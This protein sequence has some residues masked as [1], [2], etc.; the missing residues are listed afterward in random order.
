[1][2]RGEVYSPSAMRALEGYA[3]HL[4]DARGRVGEDIRGLRD[5]LGSYGVRD[6]EGGDQGMERTMRE[7]ARVY[8][9]MNRQ[10]EEV[11]GDL[12]RLGRA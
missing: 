2:V 6:G 7:M 3:D 12:V 4:R 1:M 8:R 10:V 9:E 11:R 5:V